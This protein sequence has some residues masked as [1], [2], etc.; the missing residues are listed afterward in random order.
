[1]VRSPSTRRKWGQSIQELATSSE[2]PSSTSSREEEEEEAVVH[3]HEGMLVLELGSSGNL[4]GGSFS[5]SFMTLSAYCLYGP[6][7]RQESR[8]MG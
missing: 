2:M 1:M 3:V 4:A 6:Y 8:I 5:L 7:C